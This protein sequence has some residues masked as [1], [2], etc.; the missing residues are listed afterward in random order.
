ML[1]FHRDGSLSKTLR[2][3]LTTFA[4]TLA[5]SLGVFSSSYAQVS[6]A[7]STRDSPLKE[8]SSRQAGYE[9]VPEFGGPT[10]VGT[11]LK[12]DD[13][14]K[15]PLY[16]FDQLQQLL[17]PY[18]GLKQQLHDE[19]G[20]SF[21]FDYTT[22]YQRVTDSPGRDHA[23]SGIFRSY[24]EWT[25]LGR[26]SGNTGSLVYRVEHRHQVG[27]AITPFVLGF[28]AGS[29]LPTAVAFNDF[30]WGVTNLYWQQR[31]FDGKLTGIIGQIDVTDFLDI[32]GMINYLTAF[33]NF[34][35]SVNPAIAV[36]NQG[37]GATIGGFAS[38]HFYIVAALADANGDPTK[39]GFD[40]FFDDHEYFTHVE[41]GWVSSFAKRYLDN[42]HL[43][44]WHVDERNQAMVPDSWGLAFSAT[45]FVDD[46]W[47]PFL[48]LGWS[49]GDAAALEASASLGV[50]H[51]F[52]QRGDLL[53]VGLNWGRPTVGTL[54]DQYT[55]ELFYRLQFSPNF[56]LTPDIQYIHHPALNPEEDHV[57]AF[58]IRARLTL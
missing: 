58:G 26:E 37:L 39:S 23:A 6:D 36:P 14:P 11:Q 42:V 18:Y 30:G 38:E 21:S 43:V 49:D 1:M 54:D 10:S 40:T 50:G 55:T 29:T 20:F 25:L 41:V 3:V 47:M 22:L 13:A 48:R 31:W 27:T 12:E 35:F 53:G 56:A 28:E 33:T 24:G 2:T 9:D 57:F 8:E 52:R 51:Y 45:T 46:R 32:Y 34:A 5:V 15:Q 4:L 16:R 7:P 17:R 19:L 44:V